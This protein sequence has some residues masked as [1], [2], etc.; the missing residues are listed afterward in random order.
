MSQK[1][2]FELIGHVQLAGLSGATSTI[3]TTIEAPNQQEAEEKFRA[4]LLR[5]TQPVVI[6]CRDATLDDMEAMFRT[7]F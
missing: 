1:L 2:K 3:R 4:F 6:S 5:K 7:I